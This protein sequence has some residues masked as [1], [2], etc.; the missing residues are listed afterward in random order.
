MEQCEK[1]PIKIVEEYKN[2]KKDLEV[3]FTNYIAKWFKDHPYVEQLYV[4]DHGSIYGNSMFLHNNRN[5]H[6]TV[7]MKS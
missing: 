4:S 1:C 6:C 5:I 2:L 7:T 3:D